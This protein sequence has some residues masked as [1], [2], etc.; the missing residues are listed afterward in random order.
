M[1]VK[2]CDGAATPLFPNDPG[3]EIAALERLRGTGLAPRPLGHAATALGPVLAYEHVEAPAP[4]EPEATARALARL[5]ALPHGGLRRP[6]PP[7]ARLADLL[8][9]LADPPAR[10][11][12]ALRA[13]DPDEGPTAFLHGDPTPG[14]ALG[15]PGGCVLI[16]WQC[17]AAGDPCDDLAILLSPAMR[18]LDGLAP[19]PPDRARAVL[20]AYGSPALAGRLAASW[21]M[22]RAIL[23]AHCLWR[24]ERGWPGAA[25]AAALEMEA[26]A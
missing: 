12:E 21:P 8:S 9:R 5:H 17:P 6:P 24:A 10:L 4:A 22:R 26:M 23:A 7:R 19:L 3:A 11:R 2:L 18:R 13:P 15:A 16:D 25:E 14:N 1:V 20:R